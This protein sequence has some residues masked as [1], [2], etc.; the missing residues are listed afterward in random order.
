MRYGVYYSGGLDWTFGGLPMDDLTTMLAAIPHSPEYC[1][2]ADAHWRE[3]IERVAPD[4]LWNDIHY[5]HQAR[6]EQLVA[7]FYSRGLGRSFGYNAWETEADM[8][9]AEQLIR[10]FIGIVADGGNLL[11]NVGPTATGEIPAAQAARLDALGRW[12]RSNGEA[13]YATR[14]AVRHT[15]TTSSGQTVRYTERGRVTYPIVLDPPTAREVELDL[16]RAHG[17]TIRRLG[18]RGEL[19]WSF[20]DH[21]CRIEL[22]AAPPREAAIAFAVDAG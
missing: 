5:A 2:Y 18:A 22:P 17:A 4:V 20:S 6:P 10:M 13:I 8:L 14:P 19:P 21:G 15:G 12:L 16:R 3:L 11:L 9:P 1:A 7:D